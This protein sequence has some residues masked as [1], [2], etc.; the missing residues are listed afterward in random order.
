MRLRIVTAL[1]LA[2]P[3]LVSAQTPRTPVT[4]RSGPMLRG[5]LRRDQVKERVRQFV[6]AHN[7]EANKHGTGKFGLISLDAP[8]YEDGVTTLADR[9][10][11]SIWDE[12]P[13]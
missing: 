5:S 12:V 11:R 6:T 2:A 10:T 3:A 13:L 7:R 4:L 8:I 1:L 9:A